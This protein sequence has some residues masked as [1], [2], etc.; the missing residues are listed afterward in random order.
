MSL[1]TKTFERG[2]NL[3]EEGE[4]GREA[5]LI[6]K[7]YVS[8]WRIEGGQRVDL[9]THCEGEIVGE[10]ALIDNTTRS[11]TVTAED[12]VEVE[13][14]SNDD[15][16]NML[17]RAPEPLAAILHQLMESIR[18]SNDLV[19]MYASLVKGSDLNRTKIGPV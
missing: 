11:A 9:A 14:I 19:E 12:S 2:E 6:K 13:V 8:I 1:T 17:S 4:P 18:C 15:L 10:M 16:Q 3:F 7:G 5:Y